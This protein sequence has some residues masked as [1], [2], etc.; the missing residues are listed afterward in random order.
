MLCVHTVPNHSLCNA[1]VTLGS[2]Y[3]RTALAAACDSF[4]CMFS[5]MASLSLLLAVYLLT[6]LQTKQ[7][8][9]E[10][11]R[12]RLI[13]KRHQVQRLRAQLQITVQYGLMAWNFAGCLQ[14]PKY[15]G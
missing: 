6:L 8:R 12:R 11:A 10:W 13:G 7:Q 4:T 1:I 15:P 2:T 3:I 14:V 5:N 9:R